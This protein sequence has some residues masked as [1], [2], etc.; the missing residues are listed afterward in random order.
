MKDSSSAVDFEEESGSNE[1]ESL[2]FIRTRWLP[3]SAALERCLT[4][5]RWTFPRTPT[6]W[7]SLAVEV[8]TNHL[9]PTSSGRTLT[10]QPCHCVSAASSNDLGFH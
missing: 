2:L 10:F 7:S 5:C 4:A 1:V 3:F 9:Q 8:S 6:F